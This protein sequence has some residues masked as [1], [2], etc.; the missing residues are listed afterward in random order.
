MWKNWDLPWFWGAPPRWKNH[1]P[2]RLAYQ[3][4]DIRRRRN[5]IGNCFLRLVLKMSLEMFAKWSKFMFL[6]VFVSLFLSKLCPVLVL[7]VLKNFILSGF[8]L[9]WNRFWLSDEN[10]CLGCSE[11]MIFMTSEAV[12]ILPDFQVLFY[13]FCWGDFCSELFANYF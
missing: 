7:A 1:I 12:R 9:S 13:Q 4:Q 6:N 3:H 10:S 8:L 11:L 2:Q 5:R